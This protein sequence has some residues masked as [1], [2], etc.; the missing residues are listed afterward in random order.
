MRPQVRTDEPKSGRPLASSV[1]RSQ[2]QIEPFAHL[3]LHKTQNTRHN[4]QNTKHSSV[5]RSQKQIKPF[6]QPTFVYIKHKTQNKTQH[7]RDKTRH[8]TQNTASFSYN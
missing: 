5:T 7:T 4:T 3:C 2:K 1:T 8:K 6:A